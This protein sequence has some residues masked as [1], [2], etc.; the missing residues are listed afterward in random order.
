MISSFVLVGYSTAPRE[1]QGCGV[2]H[3]SP[4]GMSKNA[5]AHCE[6]GEYGAIIWIMK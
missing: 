4:L 2:D 3:T 6:L 5:H 1:I